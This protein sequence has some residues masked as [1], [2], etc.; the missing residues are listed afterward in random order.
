MGLSTSGMMTCLEMHRIAQHGSIQPR[1]RRNEPD[2]RGFE[3]SAETMLPPAPST[4]F[5]QV[6][7]DGRISCAQ[8]RQIE[9]RASDLLGSDGQQAT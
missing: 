4:L 9:A 5:S 2:A 6:Q 3:C 1:R 7:V 8:C